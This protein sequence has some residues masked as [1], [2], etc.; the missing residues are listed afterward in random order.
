MV[1][2]LI[3]YLW[4]FV[5]KYESSPGKIR[6][7]YKSITGKNKDA[8]KIKTVMNELRYISP[9]VLGPVHVQQEGNFHPVVS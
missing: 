7:P 4:P 1:I 2:S 5:L 3:I 6:G 8:I 9:V